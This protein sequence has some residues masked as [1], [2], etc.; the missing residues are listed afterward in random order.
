M[1]RLL[2][3][4]FELVGLVLNLTGRFVA[5]ILGLVL[6]ALGALLSSTVIGACLGVPLLA[7]G[8]LLLV[9]GIF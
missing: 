4:P 3:L 6:M 2:M 8:F 1:T 9:K 7:F 5:V